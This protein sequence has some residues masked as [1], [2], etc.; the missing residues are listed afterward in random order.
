MTETVYCVRYVSRSGGHRGYSIRD[1]LAEAKAL[2][3]EY[4]ARGHK[5]TITECNR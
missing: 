2:A 4:K 1:T 3:A 5:V